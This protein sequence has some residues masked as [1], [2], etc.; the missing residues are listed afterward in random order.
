MIRGSLEVHTF[1]KKQTNKQ[2]VCHVR[3]KVCLT[4]VI[5]SPFSTKSAPKISDQS[6]REGHFLYLSW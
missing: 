6:G 1:M 3:R 4:K 2:R 5:V